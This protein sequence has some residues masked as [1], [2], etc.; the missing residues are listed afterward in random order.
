M[1]A[2]LT[3]APAVKS[4]F[5]SRK[6]SKSPAI[7]AASSPPRLPVA[8]DVQLDEAHFRTETA[9]GLYETLR[10]RA[11]LVVVEVR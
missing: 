2:V 10:T 8:V 1:P 9:Y 11:L 6:Q 3:Q 5:W 7:A 4:S